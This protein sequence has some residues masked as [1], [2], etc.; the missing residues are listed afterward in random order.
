PDIHG[1]LPLAGVAAGGPA[2]GAALLAAGIVAGKQLDQIAEVNYQVKGSWDNP[3]VVRVARKKL[4]GG[5]QRQKLDQ[6]F[7]DPHSESINRES[8]RSESSGKGKN[9]IGKGYDDPLA[10]FQ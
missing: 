8:W 9:P 6:P 1:L 3:D 7:V 4:F 2:V 10:D 5:S